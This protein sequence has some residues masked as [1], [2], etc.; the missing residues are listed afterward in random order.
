MSVTFGKVVSVARWGQKPE[1]QASR[2]KASGE[3][4]QRHIPW[5]NREGKRWSGRWGRAKA[6]YWFLPSS[7]L[8]SE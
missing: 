2:R 3:D 7:K 8:H 6:K 1:E 5:L 4:T